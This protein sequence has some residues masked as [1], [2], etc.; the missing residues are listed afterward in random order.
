MLAVR[1]CRTG[2]EVMENVRRTRGYF[3]E[4]DSRFEH[5]AKISALTYELQCVKQERDQYRAV[6]DELRAANAE[7][8]VKVADISNLA[9]SDATMAIKQSIGKLRAI[10][11]MNIQRA[12]CEHY[13]VR[14]DDL[15]S[16]RRT[17]ELALPRQVAMYLCQQHTHNSL[18]AI[19]RMFGNR[20]HTT[21]LHAVRKI[22][23]LLPGDIEL[24]SDI[25]AIMGN[26]LA[27]DSISA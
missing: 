18:P 21:V 11:I 24:D 12:V 10:T 17:K 25:K 27:G 4:I 22:T 6:A 20:D 1:E 23:G 15:L 2:A 14:K 9:S 3:R 5:T 13:K 7:L 19:G 26:L 8:L 16:V